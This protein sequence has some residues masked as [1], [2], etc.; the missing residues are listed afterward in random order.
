M[1]TTR[2]D[3]LKIQKAAIDKELSELKAQAKSGTQG[4]IRATQE[5]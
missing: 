5:A 3:E 1:N 2:I 4:G